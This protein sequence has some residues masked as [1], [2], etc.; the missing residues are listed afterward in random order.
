[1]IK[2]I[3][4]FFL[5]SLFIG[6]ALYINFILYEIFMKSRKKVILER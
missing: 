5:Q 3:N 4:F 1:M 2:L 6:L